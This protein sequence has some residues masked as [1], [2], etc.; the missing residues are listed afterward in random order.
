M[1]L[2][3][4]IHGGVLETLDS[5]LSVLQVP[6]EG[7]ARERPLIVDSVDLGIRHCLV[8]KR[9]T[10]MEDIRWVRSHEQVRP[11]ASCRRG[12]CGVHGSIRSARGLRDV[13]RASWVLES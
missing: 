7:G 13:R 6:P 3:N 8:V 11:I 5:L 9:G 2:Q 10:R 1:P 12:A 4:T